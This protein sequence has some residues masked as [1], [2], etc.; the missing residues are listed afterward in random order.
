MLTDDKSLEKAFPAPQGNFSYLDTNK[1]IK[2]YPGLN[3]SYLIVRKDE[4]EYHLLAFDHKNGQ[5]LI[6]DE[7]REILKTFYP[8]YEKLMAETF[9]PM[10]PD[11]EKIA[12]GITLGM[13]I[14][15]KFKE[16]IIHFRYLHSY[17]YLKK[18]GLKSKPPLGDPDVPKDTYRL[19]CIFQANHRGDEKMFTYD[20][21][22][23]RQEVMDILLYDYQL[24]E[25]NPEPK[26]YKGVLSD[27]WKLKGEP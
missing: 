14:F 1:L 16:P 4:K 20:G 19:S 24:I 9:N 18:H 22:V 6:K 23:F 7:V 26:I 21:Y 10:N 3:Q 27:V 5:M 8:K 25:Q 13:H 17:S 2:T 15:S 12:L 11:F